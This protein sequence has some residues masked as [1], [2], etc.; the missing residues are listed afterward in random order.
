[1]AG[2]SVGPA[3]VRWSSAHRK[4]AIIVSLGIHD[5]DSVSVL[6]LD[7]LAV[8]VSALR[9]AA[10]LVTVEAPDSAVN[11]AVIVTAPA[12]HITNASVCEFGRRRVHRSAS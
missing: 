8:R 10:A 6:I 4:A 12:P 3:C 9:F 1:M 2:P 11:R 5:P 7:D